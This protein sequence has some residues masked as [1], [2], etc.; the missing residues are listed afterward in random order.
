MITKILI[1]TL[2]GNGNFLEK[3]QKLFELLKF[4]NNLNRG[5]KSGNIYHEL[6]SQNPNLSEMIGNL[7]NEDIVL[8]D[9]LFKKDVKNFLQKKQLENNL[10]FDKRTTSKQI[11]FNTIYIDEPTSGLWTTG[12]ATFFI[13]TKIGVKNKVSIEFRSIVPLKVIIGFEKIEITNFNI[14]KL[15]TKKFDFF[16]EPSKIVN[17]VSE[18]FIATDRLW[19]PSVILGHDDLITIGIGI[20]SIIVSY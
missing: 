12:I 6:K 4:R 18:L 17:S 11:G 19:L 10:N 16:I 15:S 3:L 2:K 8:I 5:I 14:K 1:D 13:P 7:S 9:N 20:K